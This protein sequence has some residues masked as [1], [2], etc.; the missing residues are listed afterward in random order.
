MAGLGEEQ[1]VVV[2]I[3]LAGEGYGTDDQ[4]ALVYEAGR[5]MAA[6]VEDA[7]VGEVDGNEFG[8]GE[9]VVFAYG[10]DADALFKVME[11]A[12]RRLPLRPVYVVLRRGGDDN[13]SRVDL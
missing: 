13:G 1:S 3:R 2:H 10:P 8:G 6:A 7:R 12:L 9:A 4:R 5:V 11:P